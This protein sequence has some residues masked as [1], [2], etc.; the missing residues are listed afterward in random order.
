MSKISKNK[1]KIAWSLWIPVTVAFLVVITAW[2]VLLKI[3]KENP[4]EIIEIEKT[5]N[6]EH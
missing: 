1:K 6:A 5:S 3:A 4:V 2:T